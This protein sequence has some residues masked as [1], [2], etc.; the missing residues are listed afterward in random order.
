M[1]V[2]TTIIIVVV[3]TMT[4]TTTTTTTTNDYDYDYYDYSVLLLLSTGGQ[5]SRQ[6][7]TEGKKSQ[8]TEFKM[9]I[10]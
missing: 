3:N 10:N 1:A 7:R 6:A 8:T 5:D 9:V 2:D 4:T